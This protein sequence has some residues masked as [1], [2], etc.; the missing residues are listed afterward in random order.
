MLDERQSRKMRCNVRC[1][2]QYGEVELRQGRIVERKVELMSYEA[3][4]VVHPLFSQVLSVAAVS[5][6]MPN[7]RLMLYS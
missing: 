1:G 6:Q 3:V 2:T 4:H 7:M 5:Q